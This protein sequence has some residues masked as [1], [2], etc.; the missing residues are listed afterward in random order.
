M[1]SSPEFNPNVYTRRFTPETWKQISSNPFKVELNRAIQGLYSPGSVFKAVMAMAGL[2]DGAIDTSTSFYCSGSAVFFGRR[3]RCDNKNGHGEL[4]V[5]NA[6]K[7]SCDIFF[8]N[9][10]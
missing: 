6:L 2:T 4:S 9:V 1:V 8:F 7:T 10:G 3:F 5:A